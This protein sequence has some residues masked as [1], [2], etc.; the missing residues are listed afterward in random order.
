MTTRVF[1]SFCLFWLVSQL[2]AQINIA[3]GTNV[4]VLGT[5]NL[6]ALQDVNIQSGGV[7][8]SLSNISVKGNVVING[9]LNFGT[10]S[11]L[12]LN[13]INLQQLS[14][15]NVTLPWLQLN[16]PS[17]LVL[18]SPL[19]ITD[20]LQ[21]TDGLLSCDGLNAIH[22]SSTSSSPMEGNTSRIIGNAI[23]DQ[24][25]LGSSA[26]NNF[27][28]VS[29][30]AG[31][32]LGNI[33]ITRATG[34]AGIVTFNSNSSIATTWLISPSTLASLNNR[35]VTFSWLSSLDNSKN[36]SAIDLWYSPPP[37]NNYFKSF[38]GSQNVSATDPRNSEQNRSRA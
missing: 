33:S 23:M 32:N 27:L 1:L 6:T 20:H 11:G 35:N 34:N 22:F 21:L 37:Y 7:L 36:M 24:R 14:G 25:F 16:N 13:G 2:T 10:G 4:Q 18:G 5:T 9:Y 38:N 8:Q 31:E 29:L 28:G 19:I 17:G 15:N 12:I 30:T 26:L 3:A